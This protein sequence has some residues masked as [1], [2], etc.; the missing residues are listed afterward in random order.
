[1]NLHDDFILVARCDDALPC[2]FYISKYPII[3]ADNNLLKSAWWEAID[4]CNQLSAKNH[5]KAAYRP[6]AEGFSA[7]PGA[8]EFA[9]ASG[10]R[11]PTPKEWEYAAKG[12]S[13]RRCGH[14]IEIQRKYYKVPGLDDPMT[15]QEIQAYQH[16]YST[17]DEL[18]ANEIGIYGMLAHAREWCGIS[19][20]G[21]GQKSQIIH[22]DE[23]IL[24]YDNDRGYCV[25]AEQATGNERHAFRVVLAKND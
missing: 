24:N 5:L 8:A 12:W 22:W 2:D 25:N 14:Y 17:K 7:Q 9:G 13:G 11:L 20:A 6:E 21:G 1:M 16:G 15:R 3:A 4:Y 10:F 18:I 19:A 23:Y